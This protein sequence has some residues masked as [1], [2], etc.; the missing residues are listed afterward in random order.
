MK[1]KVQ[2][3]LR[4]ADEELKTALY[5]FKGEF[6]KGAYQAQQALKKSIKAI[7]IF[8]G[9]VMEKNIVLIG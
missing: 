1:C 7:L 8:K 2:E 9:W 4:Q 3:W 6:F 5:L